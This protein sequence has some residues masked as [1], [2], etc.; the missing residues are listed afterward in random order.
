MKVR[1]VIEYEIEQT[2]EEEVQDW[3]NGHIAFVDLDFLKGQ[4][5]N[6][7]IVIRFEE[8]R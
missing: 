8:V 1:I 7:D 5:D 2:L 6:K 3:V 4:E